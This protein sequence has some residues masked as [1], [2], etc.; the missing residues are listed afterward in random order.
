MVLER[1][2]LGVPDVAAVWP[3][4]LCLL[5]SAG[6]VVRVAVDGA[7]H[8]PVVAGEHAQIV[9]EVVRRAIKEDEEAAFW[10]E[11]QRLDLYFI[12]TPNKV[13]I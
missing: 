4:E 6:H 1:D 2:L 7:V 8:Q 9:V 10:K 13:M 12:E 3:V 5:A 11:K